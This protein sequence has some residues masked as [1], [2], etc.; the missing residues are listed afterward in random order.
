[1]VD[2]EAKINRAFK[3]YQ[4]KEDDFHY[5]L[6][7]YDR[8]YLHSEVHDSVWRHGK[9]SDIYI[10]SATAFLILLIAC[11]NYVVLSLAQS[12]KRAKEIGIRKVSG[13]NFQR[14]TSQVLLE[15]ITISIISLPIAIGLTELLL[16]L[17]NSLLDKN[18]VVQ[19]SQNLIFIAGILIIVLTISFISG[20]YISLYLNKFNPIAIL[21]GSTARV[22][23]RSVFLKSLVILQM[24]IFIALT[25]C[26]ITIVKQLKFVTT[27][28]PGINPHNVLSISLNDILAQRN[29][30]VLKQEL[31]K[32]PEIKYVSAA[33]NNPP[34]SFTMT[35]QLPRIDDPTKLAAL[36][37]L[38]VDYNYIETLGLV[39]KEGRA[40]SRQFPS[41]SSGIIINESA[42]SEL[43]L[44]DPVGK[45]IP[46]GTI[47]GV[48]KDFPVHNL[49]SKIPAAYLV[50]YPTNLFEM[51]IK[52]T[53]SPASVIPKI[54]AV[55]KRVNPDTKFD[56]SLLTT[57]IEKQ[58][59]SERTLSKIIILFTIIAI[60]I[61]SLGLF[62]L[63]TF[64]TLIRT[65][66]IGIRKING[67][68]LTQMIFLFWKDIFSWAG[69]GFLLSCPIAWYIMNRWLQNFAYSTQ[70][71]WWIFAFAGI[72]A[73]VISLITVSW[74]AYRVAARNPVDALRYE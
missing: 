40:F 33:A 73:L 6:Q 65:K 53:S 24:T 32:L 63:S 66:E 30:Q 22:G 7:R 35:M 70:L 41:D 39:M 42:I 55:W 68:T 13:A 43:G 44:T 34:S 56:C 17:V 29:Y 28:N 58:Y 12:E 27:Y 46:V 61:A 25:I 19:Y 49:H 72:V 14:L 26:S 10:F 48:I 5:K 45:K 38:M 8:I 67:G 1:M 31:E 2:L 47:T 4:N 37:V 64:L 23:A 59:Q 54:E 20:L 9:L 60:V 52:T 57:K 18:L 71:S 16:P 62:G 74:Q 50:I 11:F 21:H 36:E 3:K 69:V 15:S 51:A